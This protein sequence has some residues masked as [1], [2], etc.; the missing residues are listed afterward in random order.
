VIA[1]SI[2][3]YVDRELQVFTV[4]E[5]YELRHGESPL[6]TLGDGLTER[7][8]DCVTRDG[9]W[10]FTTKR[11]NNVEISDGSATVARYQ[12][13]LLPGGRIELPDGSKVRLRPRSAGA[14]WRVELSRREPVLDLRAVKG[15]WVVE[16]GPAAREVYHLPLLTMLSF[17]AAMIESRT[18]SSGGGDGGIGF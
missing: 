7:S 8:V 3:S 9:S 16:F 15:P 13:G 5:G 17:H 10:V 2:R 14:K 6:A 11:G 4:D 1:A 12:S 18:P